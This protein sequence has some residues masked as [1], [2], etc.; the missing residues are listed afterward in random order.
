MSD[1]NFDCYA[2]DCDPIR[3]VE[4]AR[5]HFQ[6]LGDREDAISI[7][8]ATAASSGKLPTIPKNEGDHWTLTAYGLEYLAM[9]RPPIVFGGRF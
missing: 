3:S 9:K 1:C 8:M 5:L 7:A 6:T 2:L 4:L